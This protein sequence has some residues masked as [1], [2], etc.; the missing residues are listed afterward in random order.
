[1]F[2]QLTIS[3]A[4]TKPLAKRAVEEAPTTPLKI[5]F[6]FRF[7]GF[8]LCFFLLPVQL[9]SD[10]VLLLV[11]Y[12]HLITMKTGMDG[13]NVMATPERT[14]KKAETRMDIFRPNLDFV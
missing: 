7:F 5:V 12:L 4:W 11:I 6:F 8:V 1:M 13:E 10:F 2:V 3:R 9:F 14:R